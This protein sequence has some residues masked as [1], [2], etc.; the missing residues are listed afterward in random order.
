MFKITATKG[1]RNVFMFCVT[2]NN[3]D[4]K[5]FKLELRKA[6]IVDRID[7]DG[8]MLIE[9]ANGEKFEFLNLTGYRDTFEKAVD[10]MRN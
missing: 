5:K 2:L 8:S 7:A 3:A 1:K 4:T 9:T 6:K 10:L